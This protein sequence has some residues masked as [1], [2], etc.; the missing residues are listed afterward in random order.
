M[1]DFLDFKQD[2]C[3]A[4]TY[5]MPVERRII[6]NDEYFTTKLHKIYLSQLNAK[7]FAQLYVKEIEGEYLPI[8]S[9]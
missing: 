8:Q 3:V 9:N 6:K 2:W 7:R 5:Y 4:N 1:K